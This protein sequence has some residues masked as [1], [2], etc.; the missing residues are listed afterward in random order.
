MTEL[1]Q[2]QAPINGAPADLVQWAQRADAA[3]SL[4]DKICSS[5]F[6]PAQFRGKPVEGAA[7]MLAGA[8]VGLSPMA[9]LR[10][11][12]VI[13]GVAAPRA[14]TI[15][16]IVQ[17]HGHEMHVAESSPTKVVMRGRRKGEDAWQE[18]VWTI[19][20]AQ[21]LG[22]T[23]KQQWKSQPETMLTARATTD[24]GRR[25]AADALLGIGLSVEEVRD[26]NPITDRPAPVT[27]QASDFAPRGVHDTAPVVDDTVPEA[28]P[29]PA[30]RAQVTAMNAAMTA[31]GLTARADKLD[32]L[33]DR[34]GRP[35]ESSAAVTKDEA[36][37]LLDTLHT[38]DQATA[39]PDADYD[40][41]PAEHWEQQ[42]GQ[43]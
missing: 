26:S 17:S 16:A 5:A 12:D 30:T 41:P 27:P 21:Q 4:A 31:R 40:E 15:R 3:Y 35:I 33:T 24:L 29:E 18:A 28:A 19:E 34:I 25:I 10:A 11:F 20:R 36:S 43:A 39:D 13:Q 42:E 23:G 9:S 32:F 22:L 7:A 6:A 2:Y 14:L 8:E 1:E 37:T 38:E